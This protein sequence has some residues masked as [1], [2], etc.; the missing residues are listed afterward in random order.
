MA[1]IIDG[2]TLAIGST[3]IRLERIDAP[4]TDQFCLNGAG[5]RWTCGIEARD[6]LVEHIAG[7]EITCTLNGMDVY[8]RFL[9]T[10]RV[11]AED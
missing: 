5:A 1:R 8:G 9:A 10:C 6:K 4:E 7:R 11:A 2:D 3:K